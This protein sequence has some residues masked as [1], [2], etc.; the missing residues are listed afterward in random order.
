[1]LSYFTCNCWCCSLSKLVPHQT[2]LPYTFCFLPSC[3]LS[4]FCSPS[5]PSIYR[6]CGACVTCTLRSQPP[7]GRSVRQTPGECG[8]L[9]ATAVS[10]TTVGC[11]GTRWGSVG[12]GWLHPLPLLWCFPLCS[13]SLWWGDCLLVVTTNQLFSPVVNK[14]KQISLIRNN[15]TLSH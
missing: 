12:C 15:D 10:M 2:F 13:T 8:F 3:S 11:E 5:F 14:H 1:M 6:F 7:P 9:A 4:I